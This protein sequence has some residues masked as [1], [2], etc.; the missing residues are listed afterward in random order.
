MK[1]KLFIFTSIMLMLSVAEAQ[2]LMRNKRLIKDFLNVF[3][4][5]ILVFVSNFYSYIY[6]L[7]MRNIALHSFL[8]LFYLC[9]S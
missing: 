9:F 5:Y 4:F 1:K 7:I 3:Y 2:E 8:F 6:F